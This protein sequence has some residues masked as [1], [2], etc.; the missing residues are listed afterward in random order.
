[1]KWVL[2]V[3]GLLVLA[4]IAGIFLVRTA[5][6]DLSRWHVDPATVT[7]VETR[8]QFLGAHTYD[9]TP[10][11]IAAAVERSLGGEVL[12]GSYD[13]GWVTVVVRSPLVGFPDYVSVRIFEDT[14]G[15]MIRLFSRSR[16]GYSDLGANRSRFEQVLTDVKAAL[17]AG[18]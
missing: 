16:Y 3:I 9:A 18:S 12:A 13:K 11:A 15:T 8:N 6:H 5:S 4:S 1:M 2:I 17:A 7:E 10:A 14:D